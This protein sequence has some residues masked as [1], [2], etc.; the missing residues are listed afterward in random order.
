MEAS[1]DPTEKARPIRTLH[2]E[3]GTEAGGSAMSLLQLLQALGPDRVSPRVL[4][5]H[6][7]AHVER[8][9]SASI[10][11]LVL[12]PRT[13]LGRTLQR[14]A[15]A[16]RT[17]PVPASRRFAP[18]TRLARY[19]GALLHLVVDQIP[20]TLWLTR[21]LRRERYD[22][23]HLN[24][25]LRAHRDAIVAA[26]LA[27]TPVLCHERMVTGLN[28]LDRRLARWVHMHVCVA[29]WVRA[30]LIE[31][32]LQ[33]P[34]LRRIWNGTVLPAP[35]APTQERRSNVLHLAFV[36]RF[37]AWKGHELLLTAL[38]RLRE[39]GV[40][41]SLSIAGAPTSAQ[42]PYHEQLRRRV[43]DLGLQSCVTF[44]GF[45]DIATFLSSKNV[46]VHCSLTPEPFG[47]VLVE[48]MACEV[49]VVSTHE[50]GGAEIVRDGVDGVLV[51]PRDVDALTE[52]L[53]G[54]A[55]DPERRR[56]LATAGRRRVEESFSIEAHARQID[57][58]YREILKLR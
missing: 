24:D 27:G 14:W 58:A 23:V 20:R 47:R 29:E 45:Q 26:R 30:F 9:R 32:G 41:A 54:L 52:A 55:H 2:V 36:G 13:R 48:A 19:T 12:A 56:A 18:L 40:E 1:V 4:F 25:Q 22:L 21:H 17:R 43:C 28:A 33:A 37:E 38:A 3:T 15:H 8:Y 44:A 34:K 10:E 39:R 16:L 51:A 49:C 6:H 31:Q 46:L 50:G 5:F 57:A 35:G 7:N 53:V 42:Q 11:F